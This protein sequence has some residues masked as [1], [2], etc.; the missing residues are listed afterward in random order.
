MQYLSENGLSK[1]FKW[2]DYKV[3]YPIG[4]PV[5][6]T[7]YPGMQMSS[8]FIH[9]TL[10]YFNGTSVS[11]TCY[12]A[13]LIQSSQR[14]NWQILSSTFLPHA[15]SCSSL[16]SYHTAPAHAWRNEKAYMMQ[17]ILQNSHTLTNV[18]I[19]VSQKLTHTVCFAV[20]P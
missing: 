16:N 13:L 12:S 20:A 3:W 5:G 19:S 8:V 7:I 10:K 15:I 18:P 1:F 9:E 11:R 14:M 4:R 2:Y 6:T 17:S